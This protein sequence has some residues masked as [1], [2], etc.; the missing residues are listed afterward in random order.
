MGG[1]YLPD[2]D[3]KADSSVTMLI[4]GPPELL[5][6]ARSDAAQYGM[7]NNFSREIHYHEGLHGAPLAVTWRGTQLSV[8]TAVSWTRHWWDTGRAWYGEKVPWDRS[9]VRV[10]VFGVGDDGNGHAFDSATDRDPRYVGAGEAHFLLT[11][12][13]DPALDALQAEFWAAH[14]KRVEE[15]KAKEKEER[16]QMARDRAV[17][18]MGRELLKTFPKK[19]KGE[20]TPEQRAEAAA[21]IVDALREAVGTDAAALRELGG[22]ILQAAEGLA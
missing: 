20:R 2:P 11:G 13:R 10:R 4:E 19:G 1:F 9:K 18:R 8:L 6:R 15:S 16:R 7:R 22:D 14:L 12:E 17:Y 21:L 5:D 3:A